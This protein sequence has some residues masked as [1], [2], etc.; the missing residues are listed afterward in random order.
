MHAKQFAGDTLLAITNLVVNGKNCGEYMRCFLY[1]ERILEQTESSRTSY[2]HGVI[3]EKNK[4]R[5]I[6][7]QRKCL[8]PLLR[9]RMMV[10]VE[11]ESDDIPKYIVQLFDHFCD[12]KSNANLSCIGMEIEFMAQS[13]REI[14]LKELDDGQYAVNVETLTVILPN[15][16]SYVGEEGVNV[17]LSRK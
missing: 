15:L 1:W 3:T 5:W 9:R 12:H 17:V 11:S 2:I 4:D 8:V 7:R 14:L 16:V 6:E 10:S 13:L